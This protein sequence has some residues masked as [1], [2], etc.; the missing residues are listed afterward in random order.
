MLELIKK[1]EARCKVIEELCIKRYN[2][3]F[4]DGELIFPFNGDDEDNCMAN[5]YCEEYYT[6]KGVIKDLEGLIK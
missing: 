5:G 3:K 4:E 2:C 1:Y 6:L